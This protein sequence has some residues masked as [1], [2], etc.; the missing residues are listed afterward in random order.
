MVKIRHEVSVEPTDDGCVMVTY[1]PKDYGHI[2]AFSYKMSPDL[3][4]D[5]INQLSI[6][7]GNII[8]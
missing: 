2:E 5:F 7:V 8:K 6:A 1:T 4:L 3:A